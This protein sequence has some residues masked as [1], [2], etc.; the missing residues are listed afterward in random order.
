M[1][2]LYMNRYIVINI[3]DIC[4]LYNEHSDL[5]G[6]YHVPLQYLAEVPSLKEFDKKIC[7]I[8]DGKMHILNTFYECCWLRWESTDQFIMIQYLS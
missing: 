5:S 1:N 3:Q 6:I 7:F 4:T 2:I 8:I